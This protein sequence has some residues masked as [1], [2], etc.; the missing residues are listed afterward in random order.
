M[1]MHTVAVPKKW[2]SIVLCL[3]LAATAAGTK[4][5]AEAPCALVSMPTPAS[6]APWH[7]MRPL[8]DLRGWWSST[9]STYRTPPHLQGVRF[10]GVNGEL[11]LGRI[12]F[13]V[14]PQGV[15][16][17]NG[18]GIV[19][20]LEIGEEAMLGDL[21]ESRAYLAYW[22]RQTLVVKTRENRSD[23]GSVRVTERIS[24]QDRDT[25]EYA[26]HVIAPEKPTVPLVIHVLLRRESGAGDMSV[27]ASF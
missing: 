21:P 3:A 12:G 13:V 6:E 16:I 22:E 10:A 11:L 23:P 20:H 9:S 18:R 5:H 26:L 15:N 17:V 24:L 25:L 8:P 4:A 14:T 19:R 1:V 2:G 7:A 27:R